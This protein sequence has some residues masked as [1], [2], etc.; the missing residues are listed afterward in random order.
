VDKVTAEKPIVTENPVTIKR[1]STHLDRQAS[2]DCAGFTLVELI[3]VVAIVMILALISIP[4][5]T[6][7][8]TMTKNKR[9]IADLNTIDKAITAYVIDKNTLPPT[10]T[11]LSDVG[12]GN[13]KD[14]WSRSYVYKNLG[15]ADAEPRQDRFFQQLNYDYDLFSTGIDGLSGPAFA[16]AGSPDDLVRDNNGSY[17]S[18]RDDL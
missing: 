13:M 18:M 9:S 12:M 5:F 4:A 6:E 8:I 10:G 15:D 1:M 3:V 14:P 17:F 7:Y 16:D 2:A 11:C